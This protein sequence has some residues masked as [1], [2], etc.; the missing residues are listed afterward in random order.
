LWGLS[1]RKSPN[2]GD[3]QTVRNH[4]IDSRPHVQGSAAPLRLRH[5]ARDL[6]DGGGLILIRRLWDA[7]ELGAKLDRGARAVGGFFRPSLMV[8]VWIVLLLYGG[9]VLDD[10]PLLDRRGIRRLFGWVRVPDPTIFGRWLRRAGPVLVPLLDELLWY[11]VRRRWAAAGGAPKTVTLIL[12][13]TVSVRYGLKQ[14]GAER[15]YNPKKPGRPSHHPLLAYLQDTGDC[16]GVRWRPGNAHTARGAEAWLRSLIQRLRAAG[17]ADITVRLD[18]GFFSKSMVRA[19]EKLE[20]HYLLKLPA[21]AWLQDH[22]A[23]WR[24]SA[25]GEAIFPGLEVWTTSGTLWGAR[26]L[27]IQTRRPLQG[28]GLLNLDTFEVPLSAHVLTNLEGIHALTA[29]RRYNQG[30]LIEQRIEEL[31]QLG[32]GGTAVDDLDGNALLW[33]LGVLAYQLLH[34]LRSTALSGSWR[35]AQP[36]RLRLWLLR[37]PGKLTGHAR[38][39]YLQL[40]KHDPSRSLLL[41]AL[42]H[43]A[44]GLPPPIPAIS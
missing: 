2:N 28:E 14:A 9:R 11:V 30:A 4:R 7:L 1:A 16:L 37:L 44:Q 25:K 15:G 5:S 43:L 19:L 23:P 8:E 17:V 6:T 35:W 31:G 40:L 21:H 38:K 13:S 22:Q 29:W 26:L 36:K 32:L 18:K 39:T 3:T 34:T 12:D 27:S 33:S 24:R 41:P 20:V 42:R 10:L